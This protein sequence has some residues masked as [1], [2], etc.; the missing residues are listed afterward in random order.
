M[1]KSTVSA[2]RARVAGRATFAA[3]APRL[4]AY[5]HKKVPSAA[6]RLDHFLHQCAVGPQER[7]TVISD[8]AGEFDKAVRVARGRILDWLSTSP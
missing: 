5:A 6:A 1:L 7:V 2:S 3:H 4:Y 8:D